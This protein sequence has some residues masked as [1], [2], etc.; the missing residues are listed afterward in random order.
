MVG[1]FMESSLFHS[2]L[3]TGHEPAMRK[4]LEIST[5][6]VRFMERERM[7][8]CCGFP[9]GPHGIRQWHTSNSPR[10]PRECRPR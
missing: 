4:S 3:L 9:A 1:R 2:D 5:T 6:T 7:V 8:F 10:S